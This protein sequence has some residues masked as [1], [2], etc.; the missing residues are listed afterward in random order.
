MHLHESASPRVS[1]SGELDGMRVAY[2]HDPVLFLGY[3]DVIDAFSILQTGF[4]ADRRVNGAEIARTTSS[5]VLIWHGWAGIDHERLRVM[6]FITGINIH[7][8]VN[9]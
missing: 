9:L 5:K 1:I 8:P 6:L 7:I 4:H 2:V 3:S